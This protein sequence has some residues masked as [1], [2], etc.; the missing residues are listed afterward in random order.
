MKVF[1]D[2][3]DVLFNTQSF[4]EHMQELFQK[5]GIPPSLFR[6]TYE[7]LRAKGGGGSFPYHFDTHIKKIQESIG[8]NIESLR[9][10]VKKFMGSTSQFVFP[11]A[12]DFLLFL[13]ERGHEVYILSF[14]DVIFQ[15]SK[16]EN[17]GLKDLVTAMYIT[18]TKKGDIL[19]EQGITSLEEAVFFDD[20]VHFLEEVKGRFPNIKTVLVARP[21]GRFRD[22]RSSLCDEMIT[23]FEE[24]KIFFTNV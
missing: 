10:A 12:K 3:D 14:G 13:R 24:A 5:F 15:Q 6:T 16:I 8:V 22:E 4:L 19:Q 18:S 7:A 9:P 17:A 1:L 11:D 23:N 21:E 20:R 2:F